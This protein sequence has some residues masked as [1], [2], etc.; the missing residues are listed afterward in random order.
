MFVLRVLLLVFLLPLSNIRAEAPISLSV[1]PVFQ[2]APGTITLKIRIPKSNLNTGVCF[3][4]VGLSLERWSCHEVNGQY[5]P[6]LTIQTYSGVP[7][8]DYIALARLGQGTHQSFTSNESM[9]TI[10]SNQ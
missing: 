9:F 5:H 7:E 10:L 4:F 2:Y 6:T 3:G 1:M 8:G